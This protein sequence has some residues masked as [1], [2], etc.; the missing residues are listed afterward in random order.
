[1]FAV[2]WLAFL[3]LIFQWL[4]AEAREA[5]QQRMAP[6]PPTEEV[7]RLQGA[8]ATNAS[9]EDADLTIFSQ[10]VANVVAFSGSGE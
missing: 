6:E 1:M 7:R 3:P 8:A 4:T 2:F 5:A 10:A 9:L